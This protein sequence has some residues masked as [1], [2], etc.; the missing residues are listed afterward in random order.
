MST[1]HAD[2]AISLDMLSNYLGFVLHR[3]VLALRR[4]FIA[5]VGD[6]DLRPVLFNVMVVVEA[7]PGIV[8]AEL[9]NALNLDKGTLTNLLRNL[10]QRGWI[11]T[12]HVHGDRRC[13][14]VLVC[15]E[16]AQ[17]LSQLRG[18]V[19]AHA[20]KFEQVY[21]PEERDQLMRLLRRIGP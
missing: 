2:P 19:T 17:V 16:G 11:Q 18:E 1:V 5:N 7:N 6:P 3:A 15:E 9:A 8:Q 4:D 20:R 21:T 10:Q 12:R 14:Q 13:K